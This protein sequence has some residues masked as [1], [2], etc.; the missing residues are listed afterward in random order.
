MCSS[1]IINKKLFL[2]N[3]TPITIFAK[4]FFYTVYIRQLQQITL[5]YTHWSKQLMDN[6]CWAPELVKWADTMVNL[7]CIYL[8]IDILLTK[9]T[10]YKKLIPKLAHRRFMRTQCLY[11]S[12]YLRLSLLTLNFTALRNST[13][14]DA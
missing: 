8:F 12:K 5:V 11:V 7:P 1:E 2:V 4:G 6:C 3:S 9:A 14:Y 13:G 10:S